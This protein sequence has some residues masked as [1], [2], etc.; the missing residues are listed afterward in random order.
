MSFHIE[1]HEYKRLKILPFSFPNFS[2][3]TFGD[4]N[5]N[6]NER[7]RGEE[8]TGQK[9]RQGISFLFLS[10]TWRDDTHKKHKDKP[11]TSHSQEKFMTTNNPQNHF[12]IFLCHFFWS[13]FYRNQ[14]FIQLS[15]QLVDLVSSFYQ[16]TNTS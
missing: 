13:A 4:G 14:L 8:D 10:K 9:C 15:S 16:P 3:L 7:G 6:E 11:K 5:E 12:A 1:I 2:L